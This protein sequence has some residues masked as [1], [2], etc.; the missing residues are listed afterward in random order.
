M[1]AG[2][3]AAISLPSIGSLPAQPSSM[4]YA[5]SEGASM[6]E[7]PKE[8]ARR[9]SRAALA[10]GFEPR[11]LHEYTTAQGETDHYRIRLKH[12]SFASL[13]QEIRER[14]NGSDKWIRPFHLN[15]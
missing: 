8:A 6:T 3:R 13:P 11:G 1:R 15:G 2:R 9:F 5:I 4:L 10:D 14:Y 7:L 12:P